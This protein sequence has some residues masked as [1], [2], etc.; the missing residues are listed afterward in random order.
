LQGIGSGGCF[1]LG[2]AILFDAFQKEK[3]I[4]A[5]NQLNMIIPVI[6]AAAPMLGGYLNYSFGFRSNFLAI[7]LLVLISLMACIGFFQETLPKEKQAPFRLNKVLS[8]FKL[9]MCHLPFWQIT[10]ATSLSFAGYIAFVSGTSV[11]FVVEFGMSKAIFP[12]VQAAIL[13][14]W[15][16]GGFLLKPYLRKWGAPKVKKAGIL[17]SLVGGVFLALVAILAP[18][19][20]YLLTLGMLFY[21]FGANWIF[22]LYF[23]EGME[24]LPE[25]KGTT[26]SLFT[27][28]RMV[29][30][31]LAIG[32]AASIYNGTAYP[33]IGV[34]LGSLIIA[35]P[36]L[37]W[38]ENRVRQASVNS[39]G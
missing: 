11:L 3:A 27:S 8:D 14:S 2:T 17:F 23:P 13:G 7:L 6:M 26:A 4:N 34:V 19:N 15:V 39:S 38:Y 29:I 1:T 22:G 31:A 35:L 36:A 18:Q 9:A 12:F 24:L 25:I 28:F 33:L 10:I 37:Y 16:A 30:S 21:T 5:I 32:F 20:P